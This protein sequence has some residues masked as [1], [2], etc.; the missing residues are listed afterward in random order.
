[1]ERF[2]IDV[3][4]LSRAARM[5]MPPNPR[6]LSGLAPRLHLPVEVIRDGGIIKRNRNRRAGLVN[7]LDVLYIEKITGRTGGKSPHFA[8]AA[9][10]QVQELRPGRGIEPQV[11][12]RTRQPGPVRFSLVLHGNLGTFRFRGNRYS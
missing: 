10:T 9:V 2:L 1:M 6:K 8:F 4:G 5:S 12:S 7:E 3:A 11:R